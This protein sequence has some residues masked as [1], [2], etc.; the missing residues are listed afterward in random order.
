MQTAKIAGIEIPNIADH[1]RYDEA[2][3][4][5]AYEMPAL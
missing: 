1:M 4:L 5:E 2:W 3:Q